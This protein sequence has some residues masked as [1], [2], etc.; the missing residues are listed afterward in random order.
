MMK[1]PLSFLLFFVFLTISS[2]I[3][4]AQGIS[5]Q[6]VAR[7]ADGKLMDNEAINVRFYLLSDSAAGMEVYRESHAANT[8]AYA[9]FSL[10]I[11][12][13]TVESG[14]F[15]AIDWGSAPHFLRVEVNGADMGTTQLE[16]VPYSQVATNMAINHL[17]DVS[18]GTAVAN[19]VLKWNGTAWTARPDSVD[20]ADADP[21]NEIQAL[22]L[23]GSD[24]SLSLGGGTVSL[25]ANSPWNT[26]GSG[27]YY[28]AGNVGIGTTSPNNPFALT[29]DGTSSIS[30]RFENTNINGSNDMLE[31]RTQ[32]GA[33]DNAQFIEFQRGNIVEARI[34]TD[35]SAEFASV[36]VEEELG[37]SDTPVAGKLYENSI[38]LAW[39]F[40]NGAGSVIS[41]YGINTITNPSTGNFL[42]TINANWTGRPAI[43]ATSY[44]PTVNDEVAT[45]SDVIGSTNQFE[46]NTIDG[47]TAVNSAFYFVVYGNR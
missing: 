15:E 46:V 21:N 9:L 19:D 39:G 33:P 36:E 37:S 40:I 43:V 4:F 45:A 29:T 35:G 14:A 30:F 17:T 41:G 10:I 8:N 31:M 23:V 32:T 27:I 42:I 6:A 34:N 7:D 1:R 38:P 47:T 3:L 11:G 12:K 22:S 28:D 44:S 20:D 13:G 16:T 2:S 24:L 18:I 5:Y 26:S 25:P